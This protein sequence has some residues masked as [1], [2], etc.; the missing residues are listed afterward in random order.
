MYLPSETDY[1]DIHTHGSG[2]VSG[3]FYVETLMAHEER[4]PV[5]TAGKA[6][7]Y[8]IHPWFVTHDNRDVLLKNVQKN[9]VNQSVIA[10]G[11]SGFDKIRGP[12]LELQREIFEKQVMI[13][14]ANSKPVIIHCVRAWDELLMAHKKLRP[15]S[16][17]L[18]HG[19]RGNPELAMQL[20]TRGMYLS[21]WFDFITR[22]ES[23]ALVRTLPSGRIFL[24]TDGA[25]INIADIYNKVSA[26]LS[27]EVDDLK[28]IIYSNFLEFFHNPS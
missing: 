6:F 28:K 18:V 22:P 14:E 13:A 5:E 4:E 23:S 20:I 8:G 10:V 12:E 2:Q 11:E 26:D 16:P 9:A 27:I 19:F 3:V 24:E 15:V 7:I 17:W 21:F 1:I 25:G